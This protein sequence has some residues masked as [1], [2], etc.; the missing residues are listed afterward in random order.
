MIVFTLLWAIQLQLFAF[1]FPFFLLLSVCLRLFHFSNSSIYQGIPQLVYV[2][3]KLFFFFCYVNRRFSTSKRLYVFI[4]RTFFN[5]DPFVVIKRVKRWKLK[6]CGACS[7]LLFHTYF[8]LLHNMTFI[9]ELYKLYFFFSFY[10]F[11]HCNS[12]S[13]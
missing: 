4:Q 12:N 5:N 2:L 3:R 13:N 11:I 10:Q 9:W 6:L 1:F 8:L 7:R